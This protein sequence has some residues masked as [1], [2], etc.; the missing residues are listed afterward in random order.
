MSTQDSVNTGNRKSTKRR[1]K[2]GATLEDLEGRVLLS[3]VHH[4][5]IHRAA[6]VH[7]VPAHHAK[8]VSH[9]KSAS[10]ARVDTST[11][12]TPE[13]ARPLP[14]HRQGD[15]R[16]DHQCGADDHNPASD[17]RSAHREWGYCKHRQRIE[18]LGEYKPD[19]ARTGR[20]CLAVKQFGFHWYNELDLW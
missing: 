20:D 4:V 6:H 12:M 9:A 17:Q 13:S 15:R 11:G 10:H 8:V 18:H 14:Q 5:Q 3:S 2:F 7:V 19:L 16:G 1:V